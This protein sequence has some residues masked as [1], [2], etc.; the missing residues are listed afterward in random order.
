MN[1]PGTGPV[2]ALLGEGR[3][4]E[5]GDYTK[6]ASLSDE[7]AQLATALAA[8]TM[9]VGPIAAKGLD[10]LIAAR[11][12]PWSAKASTSPRQR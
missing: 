6:G 11:E 2:G 1:G 9:L 7:Q 10:A 12:A 8:L 4:D 3:K 5:S